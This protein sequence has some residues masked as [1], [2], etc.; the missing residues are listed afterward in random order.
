M[1]AAHI[2]PLTQGED[3]MSEQPG[4]GEVTSD[5][6][7][8]SALTYIFT[9]LVPIIILLMQDKKERPFI[10]AHNAQA[11]AW[12]VVFY[13]VVTITSFFVIGLCIWPLGLLLQLYWAYKAYQ[14]NYINIP[15]ITD[16]VKN[17]GWA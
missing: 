4:M 13:V 17:Q 3:V 5:D 2:Q 16:F 9:P 15:V 10:R 6:K 11:L 14:G 1:Q 8:W 12:G 7:L